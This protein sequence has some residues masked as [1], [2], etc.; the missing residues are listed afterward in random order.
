MSFGGPNTQY[1]FIKPPLKG[2]F[3]LDHDRTCSHIVEEYLHCLRKVRKADI[4][5]VADQD[6]CRAAMKYYFECRMQNGLMDREEW[7]K[8]GLSQ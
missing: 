1:L 3:P 7:D 6:V 8:L 4:A 5:G 2:S